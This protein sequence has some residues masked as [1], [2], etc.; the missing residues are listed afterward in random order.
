MK[1]EVER[2]RRVLTRFSTLHYEWYYETDLERRRFAKALRKK[3]LL[4]F[5]SEKEMI[6]ST[7][8]LPMQEIKDR[9][10]L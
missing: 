4:T 8:A 2:I 10:G 7:I 3:G 5:D 6:I 9:L 1:K